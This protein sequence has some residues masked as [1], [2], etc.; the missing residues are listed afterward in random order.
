MST[1]T[2]RSLR[3]LS[4][5]ACLAGCSSPGS[6]EK[7]TSLASK[8]AYYERGHQEY[9]RLEYDKAEQDLLQAI[10][11]DSSY[12]EPMVDLGALAYDRAK[13]ETDEKS[14]RRLEQFKK[15]RQFYMRG[16]ASGQRDAA[17]Y[18]RLCEIANILDDGPGFLKYAKMSVG[19][20]PFD[21]QYYNL[22]LAY[23]G[24]SDWAG[25][26]NSQKE[27]IE[28]FRESAYLGGFYRQLGRAYMKV[29]RDQTAEKQF[30]LGVR[31]VDLRLAA[32][33]KRGRTEVAIEVKRLQED[34]IAILLL[35]KRLHTIYKE[36]E[37]L[38]EV[39]RQLRDAGDSR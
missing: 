28:K 6:V 35:L 22:G 30:S 4:V 25:V 21:R 16:E 15:S 20:Y 39:E 27:A 24:V 37:K 5:A 9:L 3:L 36:Q 14:T 29:D 38:Q 18:D 34:R 1:C 8:E 2:I 32:L 33:Q 12:G 26:I 11:L 23:F 31:A 7:T 13:Q 10:S 17:V 19:R